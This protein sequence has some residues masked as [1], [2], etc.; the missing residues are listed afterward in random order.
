MDVGQLGALTEGERLVVWR[1][2]Q[3]HSQDEA[4]YVKGV[5]R[6][7]YGEWERDA[8]PIPRLKKASRIRRLETHERCMLYRRRA[9]RT[10]GEVAAELG[11]SRYWIGQMELGAQDCDELLW[12]WEQ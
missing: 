3:G 11:R 5:S 7:T 12:Y 10:Q 9:G 1:A 6:K 2:R 8:R 4:A